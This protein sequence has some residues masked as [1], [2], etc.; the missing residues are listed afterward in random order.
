MRDE[1][2]GDLAVDR[3]RVVEPLVP[4][5]ELLDGDLG[6]VID[7]AT[8]DRLVELV[9][10]VDPLGAG[11]AGPGGG[12]ED[13]REPDLGGEVAHVL[14]AARPY[15]AGARN[16]GGAQGLLHR[17]LVAAQVGR[18]HRRPRNVTRLPSAGGGHHVR[19]DRRFQA[20]HPQP[21]LHSAHNVDEAAFIDDGR[22]LLVVREPALDVVAEPVGG[23]LADADHRGTDV[24]QSAHELLLVV[25]EARLDEENVHSRSMV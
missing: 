8:G 25:R 21:S 22:H 3:D 9:G 15:R 16:S 18:V 2:D 10:S 24:V 14:T 13:D 7:A 1:I 20:I 19:F 4:V 17:R 5:D 6:A 11:C 12:L 23:P